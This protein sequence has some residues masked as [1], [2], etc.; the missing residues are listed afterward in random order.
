M[1]A[2]IAKEFRATSG[3]FL[4]A[5]L[6]AAVA[7]LTPA[8]GIKL[9]VNMHNFGADAAFGFFMPFLAASILGREFSY[10]TWPLLL[11]QPVSR[12]R[13]WLVKT[14]VLGAELAILSTVC[15]LVSISLTLGFQPDA[16]LRTTAILLLLPA[17]CAFGIT[18]WLVLR[19]GN[20]LAAV[21]ITAA[22]EYLVVTAAGQ[23]M[24]SSARFETVT[25]YM[26]LLFASCIL[27]AVCGSIAGYRVFQKWE[28]VPAHTSGWL[29]QRRAVSGIASPGNAFITLIRS[30][31]ALHRSNAV[32]AAVFGLLFFF[33]AA[34]YGLRLLYVLVF[35]TLVGAVT[36]ARERKLGVLDWRLA[37]PAPVAQLW[38]I[39]MAVAFAVSVMG[40]VLLPWAMGWLHV[41]LG[42]G[43]RG[44]EQ[45]V[46]F[47]WDLVLLGT[48]LS[49]LAS[50]QVRRAL[51]AAA[52]ALAAGLI[53]ISFNNLWLS[54]RYF[55][56][57]TDF[58]RQ[59][60]PL[61]LNR[62]TLSALGLAALFWILHRAYR[63]FRDGDVAASNGWLALRIASLYVA[64]IMLSEFIRIAP[65]R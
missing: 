41:R 52:V 63:H 31:L 3:Y 13:L 1:I 25:V 45:G 36:V 40:G 22:L 23:I 46:L 55:R 5:L 57:V 47:G 34:D 4:A 6:I 50:S 24:R 32:V 10:G 51:R 64:G 37:L 14:F 21:G 30:E 15:A 8:L 53:A 59:A 19:T 61:W 54:G 65:F 33:I 39:K 18:P 11:A 9:N 62:Y 42:L 27:S 7:A 26:L 2:Q 17:L 58:A 28:P 20:T 56:H 29:P 49:V 12:R 38:T 16:I 60:N 48:A 43:L 35:S 44:P